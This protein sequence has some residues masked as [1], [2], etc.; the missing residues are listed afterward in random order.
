MKNPTCVARGGRALELIDD[1]GGRDL[2]NSIAQ[3]VV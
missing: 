2:A 1:M 3:G